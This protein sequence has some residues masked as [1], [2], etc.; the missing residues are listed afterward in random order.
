M[1]VLILILKSRTHINIYFILQKK[2]R[3]DWSKFAQDQ[4]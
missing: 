1:P 4:Y 2:K 3:K